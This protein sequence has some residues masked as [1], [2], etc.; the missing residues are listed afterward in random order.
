VRSS[1]HSDALKESPNPSS[2]VE[3]GLCTITDANGYF[4]F[5]DVVNGS[6]TLTSNGPVYKP[7]TITVEVAWADVYLELVQVHGGGR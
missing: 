1:F 2:W 5:T 7:L 3:A 4:A 6:Y